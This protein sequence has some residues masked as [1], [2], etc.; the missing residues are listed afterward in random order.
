MSDMLSPLDG[1]YRATVRPLAELLSER[2]LNRA[3]LSVE[4]G[5]LAFLTASG[6]LA[7]LRALTDG[8]R[9]VLLGYPEE[10]GA[11]QAAELKAIEREVGHDVKAVEY[12]LKRRMAGT[13]MADL[14]E[15]VHFCCTSEDINNLAYAL[16]LRRAAEEVWEPAASGLV[17]DLRAMAVRYRGRAMLARTHGQPATPTTMGKEL[18]VFVRRLERQLAQVRRQEYLGKFNGATGTYGAHVAAGP[19]VD[20]QRLSRGFVE[21][22]GLTWNPLTTQIESHDYMAELFA[23]V[24]RFNRIVGNLNTDLWLY[25]GLGYF[26]QD[27]AGAVG[28][29][30]MPHKVNP[31]RFENS[32]ANLEISE[33]LLNC[34]QV[35]LAT[36]RLQRDLSDS[37]LQRNIGSALGYS[38]IGI[39]STRSGLAELALNTGALDADL[40]GAWEV[41]GEAVQSVMRRHG[42]SEPYERL[43][44]L[45]Q[46]TGTTR[47]GL[48]EFVRAQSLPAEAEA[49]LLRLTPATYT[50]LADALVDHVERDDDR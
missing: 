18:A 17:E 49:R 38:L 10:F 13:S 47:A 24:G 26:R 40:E 5:W 9:G 27:P 19:E 2:A 48:H 41:L 21:S 43:K 20:W 6:A 45:T 7:G 33:S 1:R 8:E 44:K 31:I 11:E 37:S 42:L 3:R 32:E 35:A 15:F 34:L 29:S 16:L 22:L 39:T 46:G 12:Y 36:S 14:V 23:A 25:I 4:V 28:S 30:T 50:G